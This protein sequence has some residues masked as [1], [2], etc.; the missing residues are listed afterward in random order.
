M[1]LLGIDIGT[2]GC[3][4]VVFSHQGKQL[5][6]S[7]R[8]YEIISERE[9]YA[10]LNSLEVWEKVQETILEV[11]LKIPGHTIRALSVSSLGEAMVPVSKEGQILGNSILGSD[12]RGAEFTE[13]LQ[14]RYVSSEIFRITGNL[15]GLFYS[16]PKI[17]WIKKYQ[18]D[19]FRKTD[20]GRFCVLHAG[21]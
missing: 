8:D 4:S 2:T 12:H 16:L 17:A 1:S 13:L 20:R 6:K 3:K 14:D 18:P 11:V 7:Y 5:A 10:E 15:P 9:G 19:L 21:R